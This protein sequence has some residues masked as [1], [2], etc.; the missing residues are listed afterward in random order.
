MHSCRT[1]FECILNCLLL[2]SCV[3]LT[4]KNSTLN[5]YIVKVFS[6]LVALK[7]FLL[8]FFAKPKLHVL[9]IFFFPTKRYMYI[10][11]LYLPKIFRQV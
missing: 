5:L 4:G 11:A 7:C 3:I 8:F 2:F 6:H 9:V 10:V 1:C